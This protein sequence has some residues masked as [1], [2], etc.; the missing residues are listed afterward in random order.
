MLRN[1]FLL[2]DLIKNII[3]MFFVKTTKNVCEKCFFL[4]NYMLKNVLQCF[5]T[6]LIKN[7]A[8]CFFIY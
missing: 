3:T 1:I 8:K 6:I 7:V 5:L 2:N 4:L